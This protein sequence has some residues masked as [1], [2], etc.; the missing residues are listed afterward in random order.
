MIFNSFQFL[1][2]FFAVTVLYYTL[3]HKFRGLLI[4]LA[5][6]LFYVSFIPPY[7]LILLGMICADYFFGLKIEQ[8][9]NKKQRKI[10]LFCSILLTVSILS[11]F[12]YFNFFN[13][14]LIEAT[15]FIN[16][17]YSLESFKLIFPIGLSFHAF[18]SIAYV[19]E[20][21][22]KKQKAERNF[23]VYAQY[24][25]FF[26]QLLAGPIE[27]PQ[28][29]LHQYKKEHKFQY[30][31]VVHGLRLILWGSFQKIVIADRL[32]V[33]VNSVYNQPQEYTGLTLII[34]TIFF[35]FQIFCDF[36]GYSNIAR[37]AA[38]VLGIDL[39]VNFDKPYFS[40]S[41]REFWRRWHISL[42]TWFRDYIY[43][44]L[45]G[46]NAQQARILFNILIVFLISGIWHG[47]S[48]TF[49]IW[50]IL[51]GIYI[52]IEVLTQSIR[53][54]LPEWFQL[55]LTFS[56][57]CFAWIFFRANSVD[58]S[59]YIISHLFTGLEQQFIRLKMTTLD[60]IVLFIKQNNKI[61]GLNY[62]DL[63]IVLLAIM[64]MESIHFLQRTRSITK[65]FSGLPSS[66]R[67]SIYYTMA[68]LILYYSA[69]KHEQ[70]IYFQ[71]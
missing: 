65:W 47:S 17:N 43:I 63:L 12:K 30:Q 46:S 13:A 41:I 22:K 16:W 34:A 67:W 44:P 18:Q 69:F 50:G 33:I 36:A 20:V 7:L 64:A 70:F 42:S 26:P 5:S 62:I 23:I 35:A 45:G 27:R 56:L 53:K 15:K 25:M 19:I 59:F 2:F 21:Y 8:T 48:W 57:V 37:G 29:M 66:V 3:P 58:D 14:N 10:F 68:A 11:F 32:A 52:L 38:K 4:L 40:R 55:I 60:E 9:K 28:N 51:N 31:R 71:F 54:K 39:M 1:F 61:L 6:C 49:V 24:I